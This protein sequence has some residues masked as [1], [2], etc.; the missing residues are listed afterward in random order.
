ML[1][2]II[3]LFTSDCLAEDLTLTNLQFKSRY[4]FIT[5]W[6]T[7]TNYFTSHVGYSN[8]TNKPI[9]KSID[10]IAIWG[11]RGNVI[12]NSILDVYTRTNNQLIQSIIITSHKIL[13]IEITEEKKII[14][15][16][17]YNY[18]KN[19]EIYITPHGFGISYRF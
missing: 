1:L 9:D 11:V 14:Y 13:E 4:E 7:F 10:L 15:N 3:Y 12:S 16:T 17:N 5:N 2:L 8:D 6:N 18:I 19:P